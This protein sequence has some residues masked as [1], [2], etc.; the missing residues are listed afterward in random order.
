MVNNAILGVLQLHQTL[1]DLQVGVPYDFSFD[2]LIV[3]NQTNGLMENCAIY[4]HHDALTVDNLIVR[5]TS[6]TLPTMA[7]TWKTY[8]GTYTPTSSSIV[9]GISVGCSPYFVNNFKH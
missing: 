5:T 6:I 7:A 8:G 9:L 2:F 4:M 1:N 3:A